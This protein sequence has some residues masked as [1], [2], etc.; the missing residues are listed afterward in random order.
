[1]DIDLSRRVSSWSPEGLSCF[2]QA[3]SSKIRTKVGRIFLT[4]RVFLNVDS[5]PQNFY[6]AA[7][8]LSDVEGCTSGIQTKRWRGEGKD[9]ETTDIKSVWQWVE[10]DEENSGSTQSSKITR[11]SRGCGGTAMGRWERLTDSWLGTDGRSNIKYMSP[12]KEKW[13]D[14]WFW[15][16]LVFWLCDQ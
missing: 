4:R 3:L 6:Q 10:S 16:G 9:R 13:S 12:G 8:P 7:T 5:T 14:L 1:M 2:H 15:C 11:M